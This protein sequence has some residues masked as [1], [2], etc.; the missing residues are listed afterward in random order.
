VIPSPT[1]TPE[2]PPATTP[3]RNR[4]LSRLSLE[5]L[6]TGTAAGLISRP[7]RRRTI[8]STRDVAAG[9][10]SDSDS[11]ANGFAR[12]GAVDSRGNMYEHACGA[13]L[14]GRARRRPTNAREDESC[15][16]LTPAAAAGPASSTGAAG[17]TG[18]SRSTRARPPPR[19]ARRSTTPPG[20]TASG[21]GST[22][23]GAA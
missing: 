6:E 23:P 22:Q 15:D 12:C 1:E 18:T 9:G 11:A 2:R 21:D 16:E 5:A 10:Q 14:D 19:G 17:T 7:A 3:R 4:Q 13:R 20:A 8:G